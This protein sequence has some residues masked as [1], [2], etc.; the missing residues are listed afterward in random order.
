MTSQPSLCIY[1]KYLVY[2]YFHA[3]LYLPR[4]TSGTVRLVGKSV[5]QFCRNASTLTLA[6]EAGA[7]NY[8][9]PEL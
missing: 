1:G 6:T 2:M 3:A 4:S 5:I 9:S 7:V 8:C